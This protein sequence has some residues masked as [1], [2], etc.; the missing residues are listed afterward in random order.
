MASLFDILVNLGAKL[1][2]HPF[3]L[4]VDGHRLLLSFFFEIE[5]ISYSSLVHV[6]FQRGAHCLLHSTN[7]WL[8]HH[9][10]VSEVRHLAAA[11]GVCV[12]TKVALLLLLGLL[13]CLDPLLIFGELAMA[14]LCLAHELFSLWAFFHVLTLLLDASKDMADIIL[15]VDSCWR[16]HL[17]HLCVSIVVPCLLS[18]TELAFSFMLN[19]SSDIAEI[20]TRLILA[21]VHSL[22]LAI[23]TP[24]DVECPLPVLHEFVVGVVWANEDSGLC[25]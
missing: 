17:C 25:L 4:L 22:P 2:I 5:I 15:A 3:F 11:W 19:Q 13:S 8:V 7:E 16:P 18:L 10:L 23:T 9:V 6:G 24:S 21:R 12:S 1:A 14:L 20:M